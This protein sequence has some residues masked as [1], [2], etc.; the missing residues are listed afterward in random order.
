M[1]GVMEERVRIWTDRGV[2]NGCVKSDGL[3]D[4]SRRYVNA[5]MKLLS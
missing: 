1:R 2:G 3:G 4:V 5:S